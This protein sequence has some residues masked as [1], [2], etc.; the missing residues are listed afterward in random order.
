MKKY[1]LGELFCG[2]GGFAMGAENTNKFKHIWAIDK[3][4][5]TIDT[6]K[7]N[8]PECRSIVMDANK[9]TKKFVESLENIN[10]FI[11]GFPCNDFS[12]AGKKRGFAGEYGGLYK[13]AVFVLKNLKKKPEFFVAENV[14][15]IATSNDSEKN[16]ERESY[17]NFKKIMVDLAGCGYSIYADIFNFMDYSVPQSRKRIILFG[18]RK[19]LF[20]KKNYIKPNPTTSKKYIT[21]KEALDEMYK[22]NKKNTLSN[23]ELSSHRDH[24]ISR[25]KKTNPGQNVWDIGELPNVKSA[26]MSNIYKKLDPT[27]PAYTVTGSGGGGTYMYHYAEDRA[28]TNRERATLQTFPFNYVFKGNK[29][30]VRKQIGMAV[31]IKAAEIIM[32]NV[33]QTL[34]TKK[35]QNPIHDWFIQADTENLYFKKLFQEKFKF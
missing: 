4:P 13:K 21:C 15:N 29:N 23:N 17:K 25:L 1:K 11:F 35:N 12:N 10:G 26:R 22:E 7:A 31:P 30:S 9:L 8:H 16:Q 2:P 28:L 34:K 27:K 20:K 19:D 24:I 18:I 3:D 14:S 6:F 33:Y 32:N 5:D